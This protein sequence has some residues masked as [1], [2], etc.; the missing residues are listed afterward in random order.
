MSINE[1]LAILFVAIMLIIFLTTRW[2]V[3]AFV[4]LII[5]CLF[6]GL[7]TGMPFA[8]VLQSIE[9][10]MGSTLGFIATILAFGTILGK[11][12]EVS[13]GAERLARTLINTI[14]IKQTHWA[15]MIVGFVCG[16]PVFMQVGTVLLV[17][18]L[19]SIARRAGMSIVKAG[20]PMIMGLGT[21]HG[22]LPPHPAAMAVAG[23]MHADVGKVILYGLCAAL[24]GAII[25]GPLWSGYIDK[26][27]HAAVPQGQ[28]APEARGDA[29]MPAFGITLFT[30]MLP[31]VFMIC[32]TVL[33]I[34]LPKDAPIMGI[35]N[36]L[37]HPLV[38]LLIASIVSYFT[39]GFWRGFDKSQISKFTE[40]CFGPVAGLLLI[41]GA[42]GAFNKV[43]IDSGMGNALA[44]ILTAMNIDPLLMAWMIALVLHFCIG[45]AT[46]SMLTAAGIMLP[47]MPAY[48]GIDPAF[49]VVAIG[50]GAIGLSHVTD[51]GFWFIKEYFEMSV[52]DMLK[53]YT[54]ASTLASIFSFASIWLLSRLLA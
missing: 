9:A 29:E 50:S 34:M 54:V 13:G 35:V 23:F 8:K 12:L 42:G 19:F 27:V 25:G 18:M 14:G 49:I 16:I 36:F 3:N 4:A 53:T 48:P 22:M 17:P 5:A 38:A 40:E 21:V 7:S 37:G 15:M 11:M 47:M 41:I 45:S 44:K 43:M 39:L 46:V 26:W 24:P 51:S 52:G 1:F 32:K 2:R 20:I 28:K 33:E 30:V 10:G 31:L 6:L